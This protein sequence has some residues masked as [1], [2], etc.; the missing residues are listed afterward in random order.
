MG[1]VVIASFI[2]ERWRRNEQVQRD[3][4][5][6]AENAELVAEPTSFA[7]HDLAAI[8]NAAYDVVVN[9]LPRAEWIPVARLEE[10]LPPV[11]TQLMLLP[12]A[13]TR[14]RIN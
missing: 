9:F 11:P 14:F 3:E 1:G 10:D 6:L 2:I 5:W 7:L 4:Q 13:L 8:A 12:R